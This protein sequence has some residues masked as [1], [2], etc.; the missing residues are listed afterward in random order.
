MRSDSLP[1][2]LNVPQELL[3]ALC[4]R[5]KERVKEVVAR[6]VFWLLLG[7]LAIVGTAVLWAVSLPRTLAWAV[8]VGRSTGPSMLV[9]ALLGIS[10]SL[11]LAPLI[12]G[13]LWLRGVVG[14][15]QQGRG[16]I[17]VSTQFDS[18][19]CRLL[20]FGPTFSGARLTF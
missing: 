2:P 8:R 4:W 5:H 20:I 9:P 13:W 17:E 10:F 12:T 18:W 1:S 6:G 15:W 14:V 19:P 7:P 16:A 11:G 3:S